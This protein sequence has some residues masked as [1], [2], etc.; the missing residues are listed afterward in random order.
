[1]HAGECSGTNV[2]RAVHALL[3]LYSQLNFCQF[4]SV[5]SGQSKDPSAT[6]ALRRVRGISGT[7]MRASH[8]TMEV[9]RG[10]RGRGPYYLSRL[11]LPPESLA[12]LFD[13]LR[14]YLVLR[15][16]WMGAS[17]RIR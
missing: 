10:V 14:L 1:M 8:D 16:A 15:R 2:V 17:H 3:I 4:I 7:I 6:A 11:R 9:R 13:R 12:R 5:V